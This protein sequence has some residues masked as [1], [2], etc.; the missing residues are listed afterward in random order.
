MQGR[1]WLQN[2]ILD[3][4]R[5][6]LNQ[7]NKVKHCRRQKE[8]TQCPEGTF[9]SWLSLITDADPATL[10]QNPKADRRQFEHCNSSPAFSLHRLITYS[11]MVQVGR[12]L[13]RNIKSKSWHFY[14]PSNAFSSVLD[15]WEN[16]WPPLHSDYT[17]RRQKW[18][19]LKFFLSFF[20]SRQGQLFFFFC[21]H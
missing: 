21:Y 11:L 3:S 2:C 13:S 12:Q 5:S 10:L 8:G 14:S 20:T 18:R 6:T 16:T 9:H 15:S 4:T 19:C 7:L 17:F 1:K